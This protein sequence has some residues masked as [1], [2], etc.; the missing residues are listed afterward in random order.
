[1]KLFIYH[2]TPKTSLP[3]RY[4]IQLEKRLCHLVINP[5][6]F[7]QVVLVGVTTQENPSDIG[8]VHREEGRIPIQNLG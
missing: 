4:A 7:L 8:C 1:M 5:K 6:M 2:S 3:P